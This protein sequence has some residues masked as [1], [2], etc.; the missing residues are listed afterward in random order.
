[1]HIISMPVTGTWTRNSMFSA[2]EIHLCSCPSGT[3]S[4]MDTILLATTTDSFLQGLKFTSVQCGHITVFFYVCLFLANFTFVRLIHVVG[5]GCSLH[6][7][8]D[9][10]DLISEKAMALHCNT[11]PWKIPWT[12]EPGRLQSMGLLRVRHN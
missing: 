5:F 4:R 12:E 2:P 8:F 6:I 10:W 1:M 7:L 3:A 11:L 9:L